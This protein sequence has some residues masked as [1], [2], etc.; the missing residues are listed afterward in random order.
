MNAVSQDRAET[1]SLSNNPW[2]RMA[3]IA[4]SMLA[5]ISVGILIA[6]TPATLLANPLGVFEGRLILGSSPLLLIL[7]RI[8]L[9]ISLFAAAFSVGL[10]ILLFVKK[11]SDRLSLYL[12]FYLLAHGILFAGAIELLQSFW[13]RASWVN[14]F[15]LLPIYIGP[16]TMAVVGLFPDGRFIPS[17]SRWLIPWSTVLAL[18]SI[19]GLNELLP[20]EPSFTNMILGGGAIL[21]AL[22]LTFAGFYAQAYRYRYVS[23]LIQRQQ[24][25][26]VLYGIVLW[27]ACV[28]LSSIPWAAAFGLPP[29]ATAPWWLIVSELI[30]ALSTLILPVS[31]TIAVMRYRLWDIDLVVNRTLVFGALTLLIIV[32]YVVVIGV[33]GAFFQS[34]DNLLVSLMA[35]GLAAI[36]FQPLRERLQRGVNRVMYGERDDPYAVLSR[37]GRRLEA[38]QSPE[39]TLQTIVDTVAQAL[40]LPYVAIELTRHDTTRVVASCGQPIEEASGLPLIYQS[41]TI[42]RLLLAPRT[43][44]ESFTAGEQRLIEN[45]AHQAGAA[46]HAARLTDHLQALAI[47]LQRSRERLIVARE[48]ERRRLRRDLH[49]GLG[50]M[51]AS[52]TLTL[53]AIGKL[54]ARH[55]DRALTLLK[56]LKAQ[57]QT[58]IQD[59]RQ[60]VYELRPPALDNLGLIGALQESAQHYR[61]TDMRITIDAPE[62]LPALPAAVEVAAYRI[63]QEAITNVVRHAA[64]RSCSV[65]L[66]VAPDQLSI[67][68]IDDGRGPTRDQRSGIGL[69]SMRERAIEL[70]GECVIRMRPSGGTRVQAWL[71]LS[72]A[73]PGR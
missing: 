72:S 66:T 4:W 46:A 32:L 31:L 59:I 27:L 51:L 62:P 71:P 11:S 67:E 34:S 9:L 3:R 64:A 14:S 12:S 45:V 36:L 8:M 41:K 37:L 48:E 38:T 18:A 22:S 15:V 13:A 65:R 63:T 49:D 39:A 56:E 19:W 33:C 47:D 20:Y 35:T 70:G 60:L 2:W 6:A 73:E 26:W 25:K 23:T 57:S 30:W 40:K 43:P 7:R 28:M 68:V 17:W 44:G 69:R 61:Q 21:L 55:P 42:G 24:T 58:A 52:Q 10:A 5:A 29:A 16:M 50:P 1:F 54:Q 53:D